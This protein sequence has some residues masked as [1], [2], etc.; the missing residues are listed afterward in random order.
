VPSISDHSMSEVVTASATGADVARKAGDTEVVTAP[1]AQG[2]DEGKTGVS[3]ISVSAPA[4][5]APHAAVPPSAPASSLNTTALPS[6]SSV[7]ASTTVAPAPHSFIPAIP[8][9]AA[10]AAAVAAASESNRFR[11]DAAARDLSADRAR[12][13]GV[14][15]GQGGDHDRDMSR[16]EVARRELAKRVKSEV[17]LELSEEWTVAWVK[18][19]SGKTRKKFFSPGNGRAFVAPCEVNPKP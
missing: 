17:R 19:L 5:A 7:N 18:D 6:T 2:C 3:D 8:A 13:Q 4:P 1:A 15:Q 11:P 16:E 14:R 10:P 12:G 9:S